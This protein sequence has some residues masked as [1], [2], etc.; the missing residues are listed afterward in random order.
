MAIRKRKT[1]QEKGAKGAKMTS[2]HRLVPNMITIAALCAGMSAMQ[3]AIAGR[4]EAAVLAIVIAAFLDAFDGAAARL[5]K[6]QSALGAELDSLSDF[7]CFGVAPAMVL[8]SWSLHFAG[9]LG[10]VIALA[11]AIAVALRLARFNAAGKE[12]PD[13]NHS[14]F[15]GVPSPTGAGMSLLPLIIHFQMEKPAAGE[16]GMMQH[17]EVVGVWMLLFAWLMVSHVPTFSTKQI[18]L[19]PK[20][21]IPALGAF[22]LLVAGLI[23]APWP[24]L[25]AMG[26]AYGA[27]IPLAVWTAHRKQKKAAASADHGT[28]E[29]KTDS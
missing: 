23:N 28:E 12:N 21:V 2:F 13:A 15:C 17:P 27:T 16:I 22:G 14:F 9:R 26:I 18:R 20:F 24:T 19:P 3:F 11:F 7:L 10:W 5:L 4:F 6:A 8:H 25:A 1:A 29:G